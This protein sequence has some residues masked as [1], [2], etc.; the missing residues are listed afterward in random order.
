M[1]TG[2][3]NGPCPN[4]SPPQRDKKK[5]PTMVQVEYLWGGFTTLILCKWVVREMGGSGPVR[6]DVGAVVPRYHG[7]E[8]LGHPIGIW[9][10]CA[11]KKNQPK[12]DEI[13]ATW[14]Q[15][16][17]LMTIPNCF[18]NCCMN[19]CSSFWKLGVERMLVARCCLQ[20]KLDWDAWAHFCRVMLLLPLLTT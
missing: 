7:E 3:K 17:E 6:V 5:L 13:N 16:G 9:D 4:R 14:W 12:G 19:Y 1:K 2:W 20:R 15:R 10:S 11:A 8:L 18:K